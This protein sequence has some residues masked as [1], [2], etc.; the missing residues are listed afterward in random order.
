MQLLKLF[1]LLNSF[2]QKTKDFS[3]RCRRENIDELN[4]F[5]KTQSKNIEFDEYYSCFFSRLI[6]KKRDDFV[7][8]SLNHEMCL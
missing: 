8:L 7:T 6:S 5:P 1:G 3:F 4:V 2:L